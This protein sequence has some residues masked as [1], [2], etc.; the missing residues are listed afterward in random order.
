MPE[1]ELCQ[2][3]QLPEE[4]QGKAYLV[5]GEPPAGVSPMYRAGLPEGKR[6]LA[7]WRHEGEFYCCEDRCPHQDAQLADGKVTEGILT[8][9]FHFW[10][11]ELGTGRCLL[12]DWGNL[13]MYKVFLREGV[14]WV[15]V[16][17]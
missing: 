8:C 17:D 9:N 7:V 13:K 3:D 14:A 12:A 1:I 2:A 16:S 4:G 5:D 11:F 6:R 15:D 10:Q